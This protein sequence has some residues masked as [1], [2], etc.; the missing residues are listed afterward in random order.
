M[1]KPGAEGCLPQQNLQRNAGHYSYIARL[2]PSVVSTWFLAEHAHRLQWLNS[3]TWA[4]VT[5]LADAVGVGVYFN[6][7]VQAVRRVRPDLPPA[8][9]LPES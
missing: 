3:L 6:P 5:V 7:A 4:Q 2:H 8:L 9:S 1:R